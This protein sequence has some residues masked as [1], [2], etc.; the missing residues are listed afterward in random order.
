MTTYPHGTLLRF[1]ATSIGN[2]VAVSLGDSI[3]VNPSLAAPVES[4]A[5]WLAI[6]IENETYPSVEAWLATIPGTD[7]TH[8]EIHMQQKAQ[9][10]AEKAKEKAQ[11]AAEKAELKAQKA[12]EKAQAKE[13]K[14]LKA[15][16]VWNVPKANST[17]KWAYHVYTMIR[18]SGLDREDVRDAY[19]RFVDCLLGH[20]LNIRTS[21]P[22]A[23]EK[24][25]MGIELSPNIN[26]SRHGIRDY[27]HISPRVTYELGQD[28]FRSIYDAYHAL[29]LL[30][31]GTVVPY[32]RRMSKKRK[33]DYN[34][35][36]YMRALT[37][38]V[39]DHQKL[40]QNYQLQEAYLRNHMEK[41][42]RK[43]DAIKASQD[44]T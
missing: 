7:I 42:Q 17:Q 8:L 15:K 28:I 2:Y 40:V 19:N 29:F 43:L 33:D 4:A 22:W 36:L 6:C 21:V 25:E 44:S 23:R 20:N 32:M 35:A 3:A 5:E 24:Y 39:A 41:L 16:K 27:V 13:E 9:K 14:A 12:A 34:S 11:K 30:I 31:E 18:E 10:V 38:A 26:A 37:K 1:S